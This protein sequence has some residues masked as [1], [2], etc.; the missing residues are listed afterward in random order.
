MIIRKLIP[1]QLGLD[2]PLR[3]PES[4]RGPGRGAISSPRDSSPARSLLAGA[5]VF[6]LF[7]NPR[8]AQAA[9]SRDLE[10]LKAA[11]RHRRPGAGKIPFIAFDLAGGA[12]IAGSN[13]LVGGR[14]ASSTSS[15]PRATAKLGLPGRHGAESPNAAATNTSS[16]PSSASRST[17]TA[18]SCAA[19]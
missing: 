18:R 1:P 7:A 12:N 3:H 10:A 19:S 16:E 13:V 6:S 14:A 8:A 11:L 17:R 9:L 2:E 5:S 4:T 15:P